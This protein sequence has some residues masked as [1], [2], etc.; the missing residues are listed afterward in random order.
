VDHRGGP[1]VAV[2]SFQPCRKWNC[3]SLAHGLD[4]TIQAC[5][6]KV[7]EAQNK[8]IYDNQA[9]LISTVDHIILFAVCSMTQ[10]VTRYHY[11]VSTI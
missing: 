3:G 5:L 7:K 6:L 10:L 9:D 2:E 8:H 1:N 4:T 11:V